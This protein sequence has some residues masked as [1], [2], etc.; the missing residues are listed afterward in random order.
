MAK[1]RVQFRPNRIAEDNWQIIAE[2]PGEEDRIIQ[3]LT[4]RDDCY[5]WI[6]GTEKLIGCAPT[7]TPSNRKVCQ[8]CGTA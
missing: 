3:G 5:D 2:C 4:S 7:A 1:A 8:P 6:N